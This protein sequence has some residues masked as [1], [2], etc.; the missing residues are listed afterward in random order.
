MTAMANKFG[1]K[2]VFADGIKFDSKLEYARYTQL[3]LLEIGGFI[4]GLVVHPKFEL[5]PGY[6]RQNGKRV[7]G[8]TYTAD[9]SY[10]DD[11]RLGKVVVEDVKSPPTARKDAFI[12]R[13]KLF[14]SKYD[15]D[16]V[17]LFKEDIL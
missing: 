10:V 8:I 9:F 4:S 7:R 2:T 13:R 12:I 14:E 17:V 5:L 16:L 11:Y 1:A 6:R 3:K 15:I